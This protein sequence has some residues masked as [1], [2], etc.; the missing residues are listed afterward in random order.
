MSHTSPG[1]HLSI[2]DL[3]A[4]LIALFERAQCPLLPEAQGSPG[5]FV[6]YLRR[7][8]GRG[9]AV[10][11]AVDEVRCMHKRR[12]DTINRLVSL[13]LDEHILD[14]THI[15]FTAAQAQHAPLEVQPSGIVTVRDSGLSVQVFPVDGKLPALPT[16]H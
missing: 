10:I 8:P 9:L 16:F 6:R 12:S 1:A 11:Y 7:K 2:I 14:G 13:V 4:V 5:L 3:P 15:R